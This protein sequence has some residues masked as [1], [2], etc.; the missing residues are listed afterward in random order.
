M[1]EVAGH[2]IRFGLLDQRGRQLHGATT[3]IDRRAVQK[4]IER[5]FLP[6][7]LVLERFRGLAEDLLLQLG[8]AQP[9]GGSTGHGRAECLQSHDQ[10][11]RKRRIIGMVW[12][13]CDMHLAAAGQ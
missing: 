12:A 4:T 9:Q 5:Q 7:D 2:E 10:G 8:G 13:A 6:F 1:K 11:L 3:P